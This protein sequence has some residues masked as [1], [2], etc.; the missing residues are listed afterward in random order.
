[1]QLTLEGLKG[2]EIAERLQISLATVKEYKGQ[3]KKI[4]QQQLKGRG[5]LLAIVLIIF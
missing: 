3:G 4:L 2:Q 5:A 1:M